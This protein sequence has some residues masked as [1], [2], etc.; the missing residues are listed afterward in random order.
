MPTAVATKSG[1][2]SPAAKVV[3]V[4]VPDIGSMLAGMSTTTASPAKKSKVPVVPGFEE[5]A[6]EVAEKKRRLKQ[7]ETEAAM[8]EEQL[9][10]DARQIYA[11]RAKAGNF[12]KSLNFAGKQTGGVRVS[13]TDRFSAL[14]IE[15]KESL[16]ESLGDRYSLIFDEV[17]ML[18]VKKTDDDS[19]RFL[20]ETLGPEVFQ[21]FFEVRVEIK[22]KEGFDQRQFDLPD[23][24]RSL[25]RQAKPSVVAL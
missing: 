1:R 19:I 13:F 6:D 23:S 3:D 11:D 16:I 2:S 9:L 10:G 5:V 21:Q 12:T 25:A 20:L 14:P 18:T 15:A 17:R 7:A 4:P 8:A 24:V 22:P